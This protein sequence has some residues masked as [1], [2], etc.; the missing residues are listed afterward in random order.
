MR[1]ASGHHGARQVGSLVGPSPVVVDGCVR[2]GAA[3]PA[4]RGAT[5]R[6]AHA[7]A[8]GWAR[9]PG[10]PARAHVLAPR[11]PRVPGL[12]TLCSTTPAHPA[13]PQPQHDG[14]RCGRPRAS[15]QWRRPVGGFCPRASGRHPAPTRWDPRAHR[16]QRRRTPCRAASPRPV[17]LDGPH[18]GG[19]G[20]RFLYL[21]RQAPRIAAHAL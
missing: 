6:T 3:D 13:M 16:K 10:S 1:G 21:H 19:E 12:F 20:G 15:R 18:P 11:S 7:G 14:G 2:S 9:L 17:R 4:G 8:G 5:I